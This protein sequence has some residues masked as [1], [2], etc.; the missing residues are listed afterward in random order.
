[1]KVTVDVGPPLVLWTKEDSQ[2]IADEMHSRIV[3]RTRQRN[4]GADGKPFAPY[5]AK[6]AKAKPVTL[7][8][9]GKML[10]TITRRGTPKRATLRPARDRAIVAWVQHKRR[11]WFG[12]T[13]EE[14]AA[15]MAEVVSPLV[16]AHVQAAGVKENP[17]G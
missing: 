14:M 8:K 3:E 4:T 6:K 13:E 1:M 11:P 16:E 2:V 17:D 10:D 5:A 7:T 15:I 9:S 12:F